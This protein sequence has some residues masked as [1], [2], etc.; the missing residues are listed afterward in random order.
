MQIILIMFKFAYIAAVYIPYQL[1]TVTS[2]VSV[3]VVHIMKYTHDGVDSLAAQL[4]LLAHVDHGSGVVDSHH[5]LG[6]L[7]NVE[8]R[9]PGVV[10]VLLGIVGQLGDVRLDEGSARV[11]LLS[12]E[13]RVKALHLV[14]EEPG[15]RA[16][17]PAHG[18]EGELKVDH[19]LVEEVLAQDPRDPEVATREEH[20]DALTSHEVCPAVLAAL[21]DDG[22]DP[23]VSGS[24]LPPRREELVVFIP[25]ELDAER[26]VHHHVELWRGGPDEEGKV[27]EEE[28]L[29]RLLEESLAL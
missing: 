5:T 7:L 13:T 15:A 20:S 25:G 23:G 2:Q 22:V 16:L 19:E 10:D 14:A 21:S 26:I 9:L 11:H 8:G 3:L 1:F 17:H 18:R 12:D 28:V 27:S 6:L 24:S 4:T 29:G